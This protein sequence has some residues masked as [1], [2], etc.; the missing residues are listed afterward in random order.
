[1]PQPAPS[2]HCNFTYSLFHSAIN[3]HSTSIRLHRSK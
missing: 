3:I 1:M 2:N